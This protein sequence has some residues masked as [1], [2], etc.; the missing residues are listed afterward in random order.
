MEGLGFSLSIPLTVAS[1]LQHAKDD[2]LLALAERLGGS[3]AE[4]EKRL[5]GLERVER[6][7]DEGER[8]IVG[9]L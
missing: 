1:S 8:A 2:Y 7:V 4:L 9:M 5:E 3:L 6:I